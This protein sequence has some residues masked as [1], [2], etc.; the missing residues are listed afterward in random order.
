MHCTKILYSILGVKLGNPLYPAKHIRESLYTS[1]VE[2][3]PGILPVQLCLVQ[4]LGRLY[5]ALPRTFLGFFLCNYT[6]SRALAGFMFHFRS[7]VGNVP[8]S[9][10]VQP[11]LIQS[12]GRLYMFHFRPLVSAQFQQGE[13]SC[14][15]PFLF[16]YRFISFR[17]ISRPFQEAHDL[18]TVIDLPLPV[19]K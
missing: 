4:S 13:H 17:R 15:V 1:G 12:L 3:V 5:V 19:C 11:C 18:L 14:Y 7:Q 2:S 16:H 6:W 8:W 9:I 10:P